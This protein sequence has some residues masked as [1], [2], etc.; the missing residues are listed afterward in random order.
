[1]ELRILG[2][3][4]CETREARL[5]SLLLDGIIAIDVGGL[6]SSLTIEE[7]EGIKA[8][9]VTHHHFD[10]IRDL[11]TLG[12]NRYNSGP[13]PVYALE[14][15]LNV[16]SRYLLDGTLY[17]DFRSRPSPDR[18]SLRLCPVEPHKELTIEGYVVRP[19]PV[20]HCIPAVGYHITAPDNKSVFYTGD[21][22]RNDASL[23]ENVS[24]DLLI[25]ETTLP[26]KYNDIAEETGHLT[27]QSLKQELLDFQKARGSLPPVTIVHMSPHIEDDIR[28]EV[29]QVAAELGAG[30]TPA[31]EGMRIAV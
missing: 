21:T 17:P 28:R 30:I 8:V 19:L 14:S 2:A 16:I 24:A 1:M 7:Q 20:N 25:I 11:A 3:H 23:W 22:G 31:H 26:D 29:A 6:T 27:P 9:L 5:T 12:M 4:N 13:V 10:H 18:P 15:V